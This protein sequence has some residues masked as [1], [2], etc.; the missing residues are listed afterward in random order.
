MPRVTG[1]GVTGGVFWS[2]D[3][4]ADATEGVRLPGYVRVDL[5]ARYRFGAAGRQQTLRIALENVGDARYLVGGYAF[6]ASGGNVFFG[7]PRTLR[8]SLQTGF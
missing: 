7:M 6:A 8:V 2:G 5:G 3:R 1:L 4:F